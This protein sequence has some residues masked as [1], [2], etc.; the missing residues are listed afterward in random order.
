LR[1]K[2]PS[3][4]NAFAFYT[5]TISHSQCFKFQFLPQDQGKLNMTS[6][7]FEHASNDVV[8][9]VIGL[10]AVTWPLWVQL[11]QTAGYII[12]FVGGMILLGLRIAIA[13]RDLRDR[14]RNFNVK[15]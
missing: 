12:T 10:G 5:N 9:G 14:H 13:W 7:Q 2:A 4:L 1:R 6:H 3:Q 15:E 11:L 8:D